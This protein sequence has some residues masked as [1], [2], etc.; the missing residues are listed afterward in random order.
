MTDDTRQIDRLARGFGDRTLKTVRLASRLGMRAAKHS[1][2]GAREISAKDRER[3]VQRAE[4]LVDE[5]GALKG[6]VMKAGQIASYMPGAM[7]PEAQRILGRL[8]ARTASMPF[9]QVACLVEAELGK[10]PGQLFDRFEEVPFAAASI[11]QVHRALL[12]GRQIAVKVQYPG[13]EEVV[14]RDLKT[15]GVFARLSGV[16]TA[17]DGGVIAEELRDRLLEECDYENEAQSQ[18]FFAGLWADHPDRR[19]PEVFGALSSRR[20]LSMSYVEELDFHRFCDEATEDARNEAAVSIFRACFESIFG[21]AVY[22]ADPHPGNYLF[23][24]DGGHVTFLD[25]GCTRRFSPAFV[26]AWKRTARAVMDSDRALFEKAYVELGLVGN[27]RK[28][29]WDH[30]WRILRYLYRPFTECTF[31]FTHDYV[32]ESY[33]LMLFDNP[34]S[35]YTAVPAEWVFLNRL[36]WGLYSVLAYLGA[37]GPWG[38]IWREAIE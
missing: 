4:K 18:R 1:L 25:F 15:F 14:A 38:R 3:A 27:Q 37:T 32:R 36:Q 6:L 29:D 34:N 19:V 33:D 30:Q 2:G 7:P 16:G 12:D 23:P 31:T 8:Q 24:M 26:D 5:L 13:I 17:M 10:P 21:H 22:N 28:F 35:R 20:V 11:G 9:D